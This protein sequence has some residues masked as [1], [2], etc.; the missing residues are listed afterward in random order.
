MYKDAIDT[1][2]ESGDTEL[3]EDLLRFFVSVQDRCCFAATLYTNY[4]IIR[5]DTAVELAWRNGYVDYVMPYL[6]Q[7]LRH[8]HE[9]VKLVVERTNPPSEDTAAAE[10]AAAAAV[11]LI[12]GG[13]GLGGDML[14]I[15]NGG[16]GVPAQGYGPPAAGGIPDP[17][18]QPTGYGMG[19]YGAPAGYGL[20]QPG[21]GG[22]GGYY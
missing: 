14:M 1:A 16:Y 6:V 12:G 5:P 10:A 17:Y 20:P 9:K 13:Y 2:A 11:G 21:Y 3:A 19:G 15:T 8:L 7:Y 22:S 18:A 4:D